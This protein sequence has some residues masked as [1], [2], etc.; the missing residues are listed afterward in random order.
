MSVPDDVVDRSTE[1][2]LQRL[3]ERSPATVATLFK[4]CC[5]Y[6]DIWCNFETVHLNG[7]TSDLPKFLH[8][9]YYG[10]TSERYGRLDILLNTF[11]AIHLD[12]QATLLEAWMNGPMN[13]RWFPVRPSWKHVKPSVHARQD[14]ERVISCKLGKFILA[15]FFT[16]VP[17]FLKPDFR[18]DKFLAWLDQSNDFAYTSC[19][20]IIHALE[21]CGESAQSL[22]HDVFDHLRSLEARDAVVKGV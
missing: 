11:R 3:M 13:G 17:D 5:I 8:D 1:K 4:P 19:D 6:P 18:G 2:T 10:L 15:V 20:Y 12:E 14:I 16:R 22:Q 7:F 9:I 21:A